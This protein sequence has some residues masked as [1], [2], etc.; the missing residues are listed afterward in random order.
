MLKRGFCFFFDKEILFINP[1]NETP[2]SKSCINPVQ[3][4]NPAEKS[5][6]PESSYIR[7]DAENK[8]LVLLVSSNNVLGHKKALLAKVSSSM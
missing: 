4:Q 7:R 2:V 3:N 8:M 6:L 1:V 5:L